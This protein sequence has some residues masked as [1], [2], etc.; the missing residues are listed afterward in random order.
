M[1]IAGVQMYFVLLLNVVIYKIAVHFLYKFGIIVLY[2]AFALQSK[3]LTFLCV[4]EY[5]LNA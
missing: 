1:H 4:A 2:V 3:S 5:T